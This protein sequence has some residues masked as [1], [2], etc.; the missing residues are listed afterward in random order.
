MSDYTLKEIRDIEVGDTVMTFDTKTKTMQANKVLEV[1]QFETEKQ[2]ISI[3]GE[4][5]G[6]TPEQHV[7]ANDIWIK[8][9][10]LQ[11]GDIMFKSDMQPKM[12]QEISYHDCD[13]SVYDLL[14]AD[15]AAHTYFADGFLVYDWNYS[16]DNA[17]Q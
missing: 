4:L 8:A 9:G 13:E 6:V 2:Y 7:Y 10:K 15:D 11:I 12:I 3:N 16:K 1:K 17:R 14:L 5:H